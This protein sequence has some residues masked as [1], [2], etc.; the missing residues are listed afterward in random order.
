MRG[1]IKI[2]KIRMYVEVSIIPWGNNE[3]RCVEIRRY[4]V[5]EIPFLA[6]KPEDPLFPLIIVFRRR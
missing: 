4:A 6:Q 5:S 3:G 1:R 2:D